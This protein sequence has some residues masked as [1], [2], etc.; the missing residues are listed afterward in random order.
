[1]NAAAGQ[2]ASHVDEDHLYEPLGPAE[3]IHEQSRQWFGRERQTIEQR[4]YQV[5]LW[6]TPIAP[7][8]CD[9]R[10]RLNRILGPYDE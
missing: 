2:P 7:P 3:L 8:R 1:M 9:R 5:H 6:R 4:R 10:R